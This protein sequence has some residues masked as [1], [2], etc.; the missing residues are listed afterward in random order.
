MITFAY[1]QKY[2]HISKNKHYYTFRNMFVTVKDH[3]DLCMWFIFCRECNA[4]FLND[5]TTKPQSSIFKINI[6]LNLSNDDILW[7]FTKAP[8]QERKIF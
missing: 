3:S 5:L 7:Y 4:S 6:Y 2:I 1:F 8:L